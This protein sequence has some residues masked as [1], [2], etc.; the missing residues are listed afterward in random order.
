MQTTHFQ[1]RVLPNTLCAALCTPS[2]AAVVVDDSSGTCE[3]GFAGD[4][5]PRA[6]L[7]SIIGRPKTPG[8]MVGMDQKGSVPV[9][10]H[11]GRGREARGEQAEKVRELPQVRRATADDARFKKINTTILMRPKDREFGDRA[12]PRRGENCRSPRRARPWAAAPCD[13]QPEPRCCRSPLGELARHTPQAC[14]F[15][16]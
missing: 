13:V 16:F 12:V 6:E 10:S 9:R 15:F 8:I 11:S 4:S 2:M 5:A 1:Q 3:D 7:P 14:A